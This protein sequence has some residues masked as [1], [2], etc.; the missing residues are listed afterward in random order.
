MAVFNQTHVELIEQ[1]IKLS[2]LSNPQ[3]IDDM[4]DHYCCVV[5][6]EMNK[7]LSFDEAYKKAWNCIS[8]N[9]LVE[10]E[11]ELFLMLNFNKHIQ[12]KKLVYSFGF[13]AAMFVA[14]GFLFRILSWPGALA[15]SF[16]GYA[17]LFVVCILVMV[18]RFKR[19]ATSS[20]M[21]T[22]RAYAGNFTALF[23]SV[24]SMFK[25]LHFPGANMLLLIGFIILIALYLP[26]FF[27]HA[28]RLSLSEQ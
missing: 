5:E 11:N 12:M 22:F 7:G 27:Y 13:L 26:A 2:G 6:E 8:P 9:G 28:Y 15:V 17:C 18:N 1:R 24:G 14:T 25:G 20:K 21:D 10:I 4:V 23:I 16:L 19:K 3:L